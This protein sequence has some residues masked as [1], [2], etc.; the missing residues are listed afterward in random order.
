MNL[1]L[2]EIATQIALGA[3][4]AILV[5]QAGL[6]LSGGPRPSVQ[7][8]AYPLLAKCP[9]FDRQENTSQ[10]M[11]ENWALNRVFKSYEQIVDLCC[12]AWNRLMDQP[13]RI[14]SVGM[15]RWPYRF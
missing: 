2:A 4:A 8:H 10:F 12:N 1:Y 13:R 11:G 15:R 6:R 5:D 7:H 3:H 14:M 9:D